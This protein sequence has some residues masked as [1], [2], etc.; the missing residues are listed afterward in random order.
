MVALA[1]RAFELEKARYET[2]IDPYLNLMTQQT[3]LLAAQQTL[4]RLQVQQ[5]TSAVS[6]VEALGWRLGPVGAADAER[7]LR[8][9]GPSLNR[10]QNQRFCGPTASFSGNGGRGLVVFRRAMFATLVGRSL[11]LLLA[12]SALG[13]AVNAARPDGVRFTTFAPP[14]TCGAGEASRPRRG[15]RRGA[16]ARGGGLR[17]RGRAD[18]ARRR[19]PGRRVRAG[20]CHGRA[21]LPCASS[22]TP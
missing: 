12:G 14:T 5:M 6:L 9:P 15:P 17:V 4:R 13:L 11:C 16:A 2:G 20:A 22:G 21:H 10:L 1:E 7:R 19:S 3:L 8:A 18:A